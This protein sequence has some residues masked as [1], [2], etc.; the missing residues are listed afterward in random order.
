MGVEW[1]VLH[2]HPHRLGKLPIPQLD[3]RGGACSDRGS[4]LKE[5]GRREARGVGASGVP[6]SHVFDAYGI[7][8]LSDS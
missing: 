6:G 2:S 7:G 3:T 8:S 5:S 4:G 1:C